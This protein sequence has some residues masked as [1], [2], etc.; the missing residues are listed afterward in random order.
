MRPKAQEPKPKKKKKKMNGITSSQKFPHIKGNNQK[1][2]NEKE[3][4]N[5]NH[6][7]YSYL[8]SKVYKELLLPNNKINKQPDLQKTI[9]EIQ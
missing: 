5:V 9:K 4:K 2:E 7:S 8:I 3:K 6:I 1:S